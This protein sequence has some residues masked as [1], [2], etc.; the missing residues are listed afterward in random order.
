MAKALFLS[1]PLF[2]HIN[3]SLPLI[4]ELVERGD[5]VIYYATDAF[6]P[7]I[8]RVHGQYRP[9]RNAFLADMIHLPERLEELSWLLMRTTA[10][11]LD[12]QLEGFA[13]KVRTMS[14][15]IQSHPGDIGWRRYLA[16]QW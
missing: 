16:C 2:G 5:E 4:R 1:L 15:P 11:L 10:E 7:R 13:R 8:E 9:Y 12:E 3:P 6:A 14:S